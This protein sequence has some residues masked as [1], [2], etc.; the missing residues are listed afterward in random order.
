MRRVWA[1]ARETFAQCLRLKVAG[2][3]IILMAL[4]LLGMPFALKGDGTLAGRIRTLLAH[5]TGI[6][7]ALLSV[8]TILLAVGVVSG[9]IRTK[10]IFIVA[11]KPLGRWEYIVGRW[12]GV[13]LLDLMLLAV[14]GGLIY[15]FTL[16]LRDQP[17]IS[18]EDRRAIDTEVL[19]ARRR[20]A[21][22]PFDV[23]SRVERR[24]A[25]LK[26]DGLYDDA[27]NSYL[28]AS[29]DDVNLAR[30]KLEA[31]I[32]KQEEAAMQSVR[33]GRF[34][35]W[36]FESTRARWVS[37]MSRA[38]SNDWRGISSMCSSHARTPPVPRSPRS[39]KA[40]R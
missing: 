19:V 34:L 26:E 30:K 36:D 9:D 8:V 7:G 13:V 35:A 25:R 20:V 24:L 40:R 5:G 22:Q 33:P 16:Y 37:A 17:A 18:P 14:A 15:G 4:I 28:S 23:A 1:V 3:F 32:R 21:P 29:H 6:T 31:E 2:V 12:L 27:V 10:Q 11:S 39:L 38:G